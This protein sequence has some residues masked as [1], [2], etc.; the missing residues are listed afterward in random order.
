MLSSMLI[1]VGDGTVAQ[2]V[3]AILLS[4]VSVKVYGHYHPYADNDDDILAEAAQWD[5]FLVLFLALLIRVDATGDSPK[6][7]RFLGIT[8]ISMTSAAFII[9]FLILLQV[10]LRARRAAVV[11]QL[12]APAVGGGEAEEGVGGRGGAGELEVDGKGEVEIAVD[13]KVEIAVD[14]KTS[15]APL[16]VVGE[17]EEEGELERWKEEQEVAGGTSSTKDMEVENSPEVRISP[18]SALVVKVKKKKISLERAPLLAATIE[19]FGV[20]TINALLMDPVSLPSLEEYFGVNHASMQQLRREIH[21]QQAYKDMADF[22]TEAGLGA[23]VDAVI[24][25]F[26]VVTFEELSDPEHLSDDELVKDC[27]MTEA[28]VAKFRNGIA[29]LEEC[30]R[31]MRRFRLTFRRQQAH[32]SIAA[33]LTDAGLGAFVDAVIHD[34]GVDTFKE[35]SDPAFLSDEEL[36]EDCGMTE[37]DVARF[38]EAIARERTAF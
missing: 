35:L 9:M 26:G 4:L 19:L 13:G 24:H 7:Q 25:G 1:L 33:F 27:G 28:D 3:V 21:Q 22:M 31:D 17:V 37:Q 11:P 8:L 2:V 23:F 6:Q 34:Y 36:V 10:F 16:E 18:P 12:P 5:Y 38:R 14:G 30:G 32:S 29:L 20:S 15:A